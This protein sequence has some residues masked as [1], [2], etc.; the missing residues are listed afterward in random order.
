MKNNELGDDVIDEET[1]QC[2]EGKQTVS[3]ESGSFC[4]VN[5]HGGGIPF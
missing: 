5:I 3:E 2:E 1:G 4:Y